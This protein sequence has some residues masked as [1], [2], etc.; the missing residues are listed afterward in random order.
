MCTEG[1]EA[2]MDF[3]FGAMSTTYCLSNAKNPSVKNAPTLS[4]NI[5][6]SIR[7]LWKGV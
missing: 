4:W 5:L 7:I 3:I 6:A 2:I 1:Q